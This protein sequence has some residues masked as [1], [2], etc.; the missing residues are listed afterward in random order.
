MKKIRTKFTV[1]TAFVLIVSS[2]L[3]GIF[4][5]HNELNFIKG[6]KHGKIDALAQNFISN[7]SYDLYI[8]NK[9]TVK[10]AVDVLFQDEDIE[11]VILADNKGHAIFSDNKDRTKDTLEFSYPAVLE[12]L[13]EKQNLGTLRIGLNLA[14]INQALFEITVS[15]WIATIAIMIISIILAG[16]LGFYI[17]RPIKDLSL[18]MGKVAEG[19]LEHKVSIKTKDEIGNLAKSFN[20]MIEKLKFHEEKLLKA[21]EEIAI[22]KERQRAQAQLIQIEKLASIGELSSGIAHEI[23][24][25]LAAVLG[26]S[27]LL[28]SSVKDEQIKG[29]LKIIEESAI[30]C[31]KIVDGLLQ[32]ARA[33][34]EKTADVNINEVINKAL[35]LLGNQLML[36]KIEVNANLLESISPVSLNV[37]QIEQVFINI[38][39]NAKDAMKNG[40]QFEIKTYEENGSICVSL[41]DTGCG[42][43]ENIKGRIFDPFFT[44]K[45]VGQGT[46][47]G[48][49]ISYG[50]IKSHNGTIEVESKEN[51]GTKFIIKLPAAG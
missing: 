40:G 51:E 24:N 28:S 37:P 48:L 39:N 43:P 3:L 6:A 47:L 33:S 9:E 38:I 8:G 14:N 46:G 36:S 41:K 23:N 19:N 34:K 10:K 20:A 49:S 15:S 21:A 1:F 7:T 45:P 12:V 16:I 27:Q 25:P 35:S 17:T 5:I 13:S 2:A 31:K 42:I 26:Y 29:D 32:F 50:I 11:Y 22:A 18:A 4:F 44:T 30:R